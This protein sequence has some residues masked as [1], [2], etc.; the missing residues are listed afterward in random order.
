MIFNPIFSTVNRNK[1]NVN[2]TGIKS[3]DSKGMSP[4]SDWMSLS[5]RYTNDKPTLDS[6]AQ[7]RAN[8]TLK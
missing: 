3:I 2:F 7:I 1:R 5:D 4:Q 6:I 8:I